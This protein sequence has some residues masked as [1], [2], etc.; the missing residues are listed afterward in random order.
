MFVIKLL[1]LNL[2][3]GDDPGICITCVA[4]SLQKLGEWCKSTE[5]GAPI[6]GEKMA[7]LPS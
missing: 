6:W 5:N 7:I 2:G 3:G 1:T 4:N